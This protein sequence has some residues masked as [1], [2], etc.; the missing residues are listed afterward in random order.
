MTWTNKK[1]SWTHV[2]WTWRV[3]RPLP[4]KHYSHSICVTSVWHDMT[5]VRVQR[6]PRTWS[7]PAQKGAAAKGI[8][9]QK[10]METLGMNFALMHAS[11]ACCQKASREP[12]V[13][14]SRTPLREPQYETQITAWKLQASPATQTT[15]KGTWAK[16]FR[17][18]YIGHEKCNIL[19]SD[20]SMN[21]VLP[22]FVVEQLLYTLEPRR[23][24]GI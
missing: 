4:K 21:E 17:L 13:L 5:L 8:R 20:E 10:H 24:E 7:P 18:L 6:W 3:T 16:G 11:L 19:V 22:T 14:Q 12:G 2:T 15:N 9:K 23:F 1:R